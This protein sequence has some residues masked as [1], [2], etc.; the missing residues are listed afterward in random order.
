MPQTSYSDY[1]YILQHRVGNLHSVHQCAPLACDPER[2]SRIVSALRISKL[3]ALFCS[4]PTQVLLLSGYW[5]V[6]G[7]SAAIFTVEDEVHLLL[8]CDEEELAMESSL[9]ERTLFRPAR[10]DDAPMRRFKDS[11]AVDYVIVGV[12]A[13]GGV[14]VQRLARAGFRVVGL[15]AGPFWDT[16]RDWVSDEAGSHGLYWEDA[17]VTGGTD[18]LALGANNCGKGVGGGSVHWAAFTPNTSK[19]AACK[20]LE[21]LMNTV[22]RS[23]RQSHWPITFSIGA[24]TF[25]KPPESVDQMIQRAD[26]IMYSVKQSGKDRLRQE[27]AAA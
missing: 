3:D 16:E 15:E 13:A 19:D 6:M 12:G 22:A 26:A 18:P 11:D 10:L 25:L 1:S 5:P 23:M 20:V 14:L 2:H 21:K 7:T 4:L 8:P 17:R 27:E 24:V 9:A